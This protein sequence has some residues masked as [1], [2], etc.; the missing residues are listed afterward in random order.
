MNVKNTV[1]NCINKAIDNAAKDLKDNTLSY[2][3]FAAGAVRGG[4]KGVTERE[5]ID[6]LKYGQNASIKADKKAIIEGVKTGGK[7]GG[8][9]GVAERVANVLCDPDGSFDKT[10]AGKA[11]DKAIDNGAN[12]LKNGVDFLFGGGSK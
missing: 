8:I 12:A 10:P 7:S 4:I 5:G 6:N 11:V 2:A 1:H 9:A 3:A